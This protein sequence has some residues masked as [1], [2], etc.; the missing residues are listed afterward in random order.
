M[1]VPVEPGSNIDD[2]LSPIFHVSSNTV[3]F[4]E[5]LTSQESLI[6]VSPVTCPTR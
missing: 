1:I 6:D 3:L 5:D 2:S 4:E